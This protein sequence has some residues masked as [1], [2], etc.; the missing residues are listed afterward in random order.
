MGTV[1]LLNKSPLGSYDNEETIKSLYF[2]G[3]VAPQAS[4]PAIATQRLPN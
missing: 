4:M 1:N 2:V 3:G